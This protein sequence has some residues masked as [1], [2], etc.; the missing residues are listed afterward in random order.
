MTKKPWV[1]SSSFCS[2]V[3]ASAT[4]FPLLQSGCQ[5]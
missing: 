4:D 3:A 1:F 5:R 2:D